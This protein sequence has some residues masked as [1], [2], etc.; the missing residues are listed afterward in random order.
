MSVFSNSYNGSVVF[1]DGTQCGANTGGAVPLGLNNAFDDAVSIHQSTA[2]TLTG[3]ITLSNTLSVGGVITTSSAEVRKI[4]V[5]I[6]AGNYTVAATD[7][8]VVINKTSGAA[9]QVTLP[10]APTTGRII[11]V[12]DGKGDAATNA[13]T[14]KATQ[15]IDNVLGATGIVLN[16]AFSSVDLIYN[17]TNWSVV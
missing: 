8:Y 12:K 9:T 5:I 2:Q 15:N 16:L 11:T 6:A 14:V 7:R 17:G 13:I 1:V 4:A 10:A 3:P